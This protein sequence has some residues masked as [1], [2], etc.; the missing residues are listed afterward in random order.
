MR[1]GSLRVSLRVRGATLGV[2]LLLGVGTDSRASGTLLGRL[3]SVEHEHA[4]LRPPG[5]GEPGIEDRVGALAE[6][7]RQSLNGVSGAAGTVEALN[8]FVFDRLGM[9]A[10]Q[11][12]KDPGNL[13][14]SSVLDRHRGYC[15]GIAALYLVLAEHVGLP[16][17]AVATP[18][19]VFLRY[20]DGTARINIET[21]QRGATLPDEQYIREQRIPDASIRKGVFLRNL[22]ADEFLA[23]MHNNLGVIASERQEFAR[24]AAG[25]EL[26]ISLRK[27]PLLVDTLKLEDSGTIRAPGGT[28]EA[29]AFHGGTDL[30]DPERG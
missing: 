14:L 19:H 25:Y 30:R 28:D 24:A 13:L 8:R 16:V 5:T 21:F 9:Q 7:L 17:F 6:E 3:I 27:L 18:S 12:L 23:Q 22:T 15:V 4:A 29:F 10:S 1:G 20:D 26:A 11:D 2:L